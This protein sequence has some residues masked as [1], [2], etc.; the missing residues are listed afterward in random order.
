MNLLLALVIMAGGLI[1][2]FGEHSASRTLDRVQSWP[3]TEGEVISFSLTRSYLGD[4][5]ASIQYSYEI[6]GRK[7]SGDTIRPGGRMNFRSKRLAM[8]LESRYR[9]GVRVPVFYNPDEPEECCI[10]REQTAAGSGAIY[11][12][13]A[14]VAL[15]GFVLF[16]SMR[17]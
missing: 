15:G 6:G 10:D 5:F 4:F 7:Y 3:E 17:G 13:L 16:Q 12:G 14:I 2:V 9:A 11:W 8:E 1:F